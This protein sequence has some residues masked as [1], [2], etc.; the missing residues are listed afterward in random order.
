MSHCIST[1]EAAPSR[2]GTTADLGYKLLNEY[3]NHRSDMLL[4]LSE[5]EWAG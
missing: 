4:F 3:F 2:F 1:L 5:S